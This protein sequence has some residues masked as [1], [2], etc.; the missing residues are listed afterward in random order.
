MDTDF[1]GFL[2]SLSWGPLGQGQGLSGLGPHW[3]RK[4][5][6]MPLGTHCKSPFASQA[7]LSPSLLLWTPYHPNTQTHTLGTYLLTLGPSPAVQTQGDERCQKQQ[8]PDPQQHDLNAYEQGLGTEDQSCWQQCDRTSCSVLALI[9]N[10]GHLSR[11]H[12][13][14]R[15]FWKG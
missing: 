15:S 3:G 1:R 2:R 13:H 11:L 5:G 14:I 9:S 4:T 8:N 10:T 7:K 6:T 12:P